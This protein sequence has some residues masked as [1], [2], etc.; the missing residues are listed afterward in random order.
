MVEPASA[1]CDRGGDSNSEPPDADLRQPPANQRPPPTS[2]GLTPHAVPRPR[3]PRAG[4]V[5]LVQGNLRPGACM[6][7]WLLAN[8]H[9]AATP[10]SICAQSP[11]HLWLTPSSLLPHYN[12]NF[13]R[14]AANYLLSVHPDRLRVVCVRPW[15]FRVSVASQNV[16]NVLVTRGPLVLASSV[17]IPHHSMVSAVLAVDRLAKSPEVDDGVFNAAQPP[18]VLPS[19]SPTPSTVAGQRKIYR[20]TISSDCA[21]VSA[22]GGIT[23]LVSPAPAL[24]PLPIPAV[25]RPATPASS[26]DSAPFLKAVL[27]PAKPPPRPPPPSHPFSLPS[28]TSRCYRCLASDHQVRDCRDPVRCRGCG[29]LGHRQKLCPMPIARALTPHPRRRPSIPAPARRVPGSAVP[30]PVEESLTTAAAAPKQPLKLATPMSTSLPHATPQPVKLAPHPDC[31]VCAAAAAVLPRPLTS[32]AQTVSPPSALTFAWSSVVGRTRLAGSCRRLARPTA[33][34]PPLPPR[35]LPMLRRAS[36]AR[37]P[38]RL[39]PPGPLLPPG[40]TTALTAG[41]AGRT[42]LKPGC[43]RVIFS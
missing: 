6:Q 33:V 18:P 40:A 42:S 1:P 19:L 8:F 26:G 41:K 9:S 36:S 16:A 5:P 39:A 3:A 17:L 13:V 22:R 10:G 12:T 21:A 31:R 28:A 38:F 11:A 4:A 15:V 37:L 2:L 7:G 27:S 29:R 23:R 20:N 24:L 14:N 30:F 43:P 32:T 34:D 25:A 35:A